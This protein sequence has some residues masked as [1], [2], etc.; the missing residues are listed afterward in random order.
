MRLGPYKIVFLI[1]LVSS[2]A[3]AGKPTYP[4][5]SLKSIDGITYTSQSLRGKAV[6][7]TFFM[8]GCEPCKKEVPF[9]NELQ[10]KYPDTLKILAIGFMER[11]PAKLK[12]LGIE[13]GMRYPICVDP[14]EIAAKVFEVNTLPR[15][16]LLNHNGKLI[17]SYMGMDDGSKRDLKK[18]LEML[19]AYIIEARKARST[20]YVEP[21][22]E[23]EGA[24]GA[25]GKVWAKRVRETI[26]EKGRK[27]TDDK[28]DADYI[29]TG[30]V[31]VVE[32][33]IAIDIII[34]DTQ[35]NRIMNF[36]VSVTEKDYSMLGVVFE[37]RLKRL[38]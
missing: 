10:R 5:F 13:W 16:F 25:V 28:K 14:G 20:F 21:E 18:R 1:I 34:S 8:R 36:G 22:F 33:D 7:M 37:V 26:V 24:G 12:A 23:V 6:F 11:N 29:V 38:R 19:N 35:G 3:V 9:L 4:K 31:L 32:Q 27:I 15:G 2:L 30:S 17:V